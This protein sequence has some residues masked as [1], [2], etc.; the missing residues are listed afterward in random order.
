MHDSRSANTERNVA[1]CASVYREWQIA[2]EQLNFH[3]LKLTSRDI[4]IFK[5]MAKRNLHLIKYIWYSIELQTYDSME[6]DL[7]ESED[8]MDTNRATV[9]VGIRIMFCALSEHPPHGDMT[10]DISIHCPSDT[11]HD[12]K[13]IRLEPVNTL[14]SCRPLKP[15]SNYDPGT[16]LISS[17]SIYR[18]N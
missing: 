10:L 4:T 7:D 1:H 17:T 3:S 5:I 11:Q 18:C 14:S 6:C 8:V 12:F 13:Y 2:I 9:E 15:A 16:Q